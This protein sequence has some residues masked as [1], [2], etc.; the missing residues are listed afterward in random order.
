MVFREVN[1]EII[2][3]MPPG[4]TTGTNLPTLSLPSRLDSALS[5]VCKPGLPCWLRCL[6]S[7]AGKEEKIKRPMKIDKNIKKYFCFIN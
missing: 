2:P 3:G 5:L 6:A 4:V 1:I 7:I